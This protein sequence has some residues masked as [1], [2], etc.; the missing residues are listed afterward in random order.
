MALLISSLVSAQPLKYNVN[1]SGSW[2][3]YATQSTQ[4]LFANTSRQ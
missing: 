4:A 3:P 1:A 2:Y